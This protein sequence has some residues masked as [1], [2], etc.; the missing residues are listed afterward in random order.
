MIP[1]DWLQY[2]AKAEKELKRPPSPP[3]RRQPKITRMQSRRMRTVSGQTPN[4]IRAMYTVESKYN[5]TPTIS[6]EDHELTRE[7]G[8]SDRY[9]P[10]EAYRGGKATIEPTQSNKTRN[11]GR[12]AHGG[13]T[14]KPSA[15]AEQ[16]LKEFN[17]KKGE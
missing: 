11:P 7:V 1:E 15:T 3:R 16:W 6:S 8:P 10:D 12:R 17:E 4:A 5:Q 14:N 13:G 2:M 9:N